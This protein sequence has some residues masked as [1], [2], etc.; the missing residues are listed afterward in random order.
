MR[1]L[2]YWLTAITVGLASSF[3]VA[4]APALAQPW[5]QRMVR[6]IVPNPAGA[7][8]DINAR[9]FAEGLSAR[10]K[11]PVVVENLPGA[12]GIIAVR[13][14]VKREDTHALLYSFAGPI[15]INPLLY[16]KLPYDPIRD[17][18]PIASTSDNFLVIAASAATK[19]ASLAELEKVARSR[20]GKLNWSATPGLPYFA[21]FG[22]LK[23]AALDMVHVPYRDFSQAT[24]DLGEGRI[25]VIAAGMAPLLPY[26]AT[27]KIRFLASFNDQ[28]AAISP[29]VMTMAEAGY[30]S[31]TFS[32]LTG[33]FGWRDMPG[34]LR[35]R[36]SEEVQAIAADPAIKARLAG[37]GTA[38]RTGTPAEFS[39]AIE[40]QRDK[41]AAIARAM[42]TRPTQ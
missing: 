41:A 20:S 11:T 40:E 39:A 18:V 24:A 32:A 30:P 13:E 15:T 26:A 23:K 21:F 5:L 6:V 12:D 37:M 22:F 38:V 25:D 14:F 2:M 7:G 3:A 1:L 34:E 31:L 28:R 42:G 4:V 35:Q 36:I 8:L 16:E 10:W 33:F 17:L 19:A 9:I 27:G 29:D